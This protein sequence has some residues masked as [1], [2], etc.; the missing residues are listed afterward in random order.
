MV[1][2]K[3]GA[4]NMHFHATSAILKR[5]RAGEGRLRRDNGDEIE[6]NLHLFQPPR[7]DL[8]GSPPLWKYAKLSA[9][10]W[11]LDTKR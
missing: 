9:M 7:A 3:A 5:L 10:K 8:D 11:T 4:P 2:G 6:R 1:A